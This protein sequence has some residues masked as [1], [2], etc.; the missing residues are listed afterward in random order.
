MV[1]EWE[2]GKRAEFTPPLSVNAIKKRISC[3]IPYSERAG[4]RTRDNLIKS[5][6]LYQLSYT[7]PY[8]HKNWASWIRTSE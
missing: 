2:K 5:Q 6:V 3:D 4:A 1:M 8:E 7:H